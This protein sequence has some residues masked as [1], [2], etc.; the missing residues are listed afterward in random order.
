MARKPPTERRRRMG[1]AVHA[2]EDMARD[3]NFSSLSLEAFKAEMQQSDAAH[4]RV[5]DL[6]RQLRHALLTR[7]EVDARCMGIV[8]R[9]GYAVA[10][11]PAF[12]CN[13]ALL[14]AMGLTREIE[15]RMRIRRGMRRAA[16]MSGVRH[17]A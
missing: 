1:Q 5:A 12:G 3:Y 2:W 15:R 13:S 6:R 16:E 17:E 8:Y 14:E 7:D 10:G 9:V 4:A 11:D